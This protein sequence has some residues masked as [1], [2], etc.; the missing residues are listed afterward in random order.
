MVMEAI[1]AMTNLSKLDL[2]DN[3]ICGH[4]KEVTPDIVSSLKEHCKSVHFNVKVLLDE[5]FSWE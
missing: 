5:R 4:P 1:P 3:E 2:A